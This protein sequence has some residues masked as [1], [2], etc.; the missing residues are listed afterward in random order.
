MRFIELIKSA[1]SSIWT[2][3]VRSFL[4][5]L[6]VIIGVFAVSAL[7]SVGQASINQMKKE[8]EDLN[9]DTIVANIYDQDI[10]LNQSDIDEIYKKEHVKKAAP[11]MSIQVKVVNGLSSMFVNVKATNG[12][13]IEVKE[14]K[15][16]TGRNIIPLDISEK[17]DSVIL[18][19]TVAQKLFGNTDIIGEKVY[20]NDRKYTVI[21]VLEKQKQNY[22]ENPNEEVVI[23]VTSGQKYF[24]LGNLNNVII[25]PTK[26][27]DEKAVS[28]VKSYLRNKTGKTNGYSVSSNENIKSYMDKSNKLMMAL[29]G[30]IG[31][32]SLLVSGI[33]I[34]NIMLVSVRERTKEIGIRKAIGAKRRDILIQFLFE[35]MT[36]SAIGGLI[37]IVLT[38]IVS[39]PLGQAMNTKVE[40]TMPI[41]MLSTLFSIGVGIVFGLY[42]AAKASKLRPV[43]ALHYE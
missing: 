21:G 7:L 38:F 13:Y 20:L 25:K 5:S 24:E 22:M 12:Q 30:G 37:G 35:A 33:G 6:G 26:N 11:L 28:E 18:G 2:R 40:L 43:E 29:L 32:I 15:L 23:P 27:S 39:A 34:M 17:N 16:A 31:G 36:L 19:M 3:K 4:T 9:A 41:I 1:F 42:P 8:M 14:Y 10:K